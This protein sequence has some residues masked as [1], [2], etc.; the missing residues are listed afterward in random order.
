[1]AVVCGSIKSFADETDDDD[2][3]HSGSTGGL[4]RERFAAPSALSL[5]RFAPTLIWDIFFC[6]LGVV[7]CRVPFR[8]EPAKKRKTPV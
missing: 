2:S 7:V 3:S 4:K 8:R 6:Y 1:M 5:R